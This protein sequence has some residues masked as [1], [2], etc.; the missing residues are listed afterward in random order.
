MNRLAITALG[1]LVA[2]A[3]CADSDPV[4]LSPDGALHHEHTWQA[5]DGSAYHGYT[6]PDVEHDDATGLLCATWSDDFLDEADSGEY[7]D[8]DHFSFDF[9]YYDEVAEEWVD[10]G[11]VNAKESDGDR[12]ACYDLSEWEDGTYPFQVTGM[13]KDGTGQGTT[14]HHTDTW[15]GDVVIGAPWS[16]ELVGG[17]VQDLE[18][19]ANT[20]VLTLDYE[21]YHG[22]DLVADCAIEP[23]VDWPADVEKHDC[24]ETTG[25]RTLHL[26]N[27]DRGTGGVF[28]LGFHWGDPSNPFA[29]FEITTEAPG[30]GATPTGQG[31]R[32]R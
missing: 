12:T 20:A 10:L 17:N 5:G 24:D 29:T 15:E 7:A 32:N 21:L 16:V 3:A 30:G 28:T 27:P 1:A 2:T 25:V 19:N 6:E 31:G 9:A 23:D 13:A 11:D 14:T 18:Q 4:A 8:A 22:D 26:E